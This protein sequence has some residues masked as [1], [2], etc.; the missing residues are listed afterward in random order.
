MARKDLY[1]ILGVPGDADQ[2]TIRRAYRHLVVAVHPDTGRP[3]DVSRFREIQNA[4]QVLGDTGLRRSY[5]FEI[6]PT[7]RVLK[8]EP[9]P[10]GRGAVRVPDDFDV[11]SPSIGEFLDHVAQNF[12]G[13]HLKSAGP[14]RHLAI[15]I[16][17]NHDEAVFG[18][19]VPFTI[20]VFAAC[21]RCRGGGDLGWGRCPVCNGW[22]GVEKSLPL[23]VRI[24]PW[25]R[26]G[27][28]H[29]IDLAEFG[30]RNLVLDLTLVVA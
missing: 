24:D 17:L 25:A 21:K 26:S 9:N 16:V 23:M 8:R 20:P 7:S 19:D 4:Y 27:A 30:I 13:F 6:Q 10:M 14:I 22:G 18:C 5:D 2:E 3:L 1:S 11:F 29:E 15:E 28:R 12:F